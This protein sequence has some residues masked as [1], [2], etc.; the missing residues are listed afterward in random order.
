M[1][2]AMMV[3][4]WG[5]TTLF[6]NG[7]FEVEIEQA[8]RLV[9]R[10]VT[11]ETE[12]VAEVIGDRADI[13]LQDGRIITLDGLFMLPRIRAASPLAEQLGCVFEDG[14]LGPFIQT[15][16]TKQTT[17]EGVF[18]CGDAARAAG[19]I[20]SAVGDGATAG[21]AAHQSLIFR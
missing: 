16:A 18:A 15:D 9:A 1:H 12:L 21:A 11:I 2:Q 7:A 19:S 5:R 10:G 17:V 4:D 3:P 6:I 20:S 8:E 13:K 14:P